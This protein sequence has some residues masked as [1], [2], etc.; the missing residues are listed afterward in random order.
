MKDVELIAI[1]NYQQVREAFAEELSHAF[2]GNMSSISYLQHKL[3]ERPLIQKGIVQGIV[4]GGTN[5]ITTIE[6][7]LSDGKRNTLDLKTG[8]LPNL[9]D[10]GTLLSFLKE[11]VS[12]QALA[13]GINFGFPL[14]PVLGP[15]G[16]LD[17]K[18]IEPTKEH[19]FD[20]LIGSTIG[21]LVREAFERDIPVSVANDTVCLTLAGND[22]EDGSMIAGT[23]FNIGL[24][25][26]GNI[27]VN[28]EAGNF[29]KFEPSEAIVA[30]DTFS[31][32]PGKQLFEKII[33]GKYLAEVFNIKAEKMGLII[34]KLTT[35][36]EL[37]ALSQEE[38][39]GDANNIARKLLERSAF[40]VAA[41]LA[42]VYDFTDR[43]QSLTIIGEGSL[44]WRG[45]RYT[46]NIEKQLGKLGVPKN[47]I[48]IKHVQDSSIRGAIGLLTS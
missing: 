14:E 24:R 40:L 26:A 30:V 36:Q 38:D 8:I 33:S 44:L 25:Q 17:G 42:G 15:H 5:Y 6:D 23:G 48:R 46:E 21:D 11:H 39:D 32:M 43:P 4:I 29:D 3:P 1:P 10:K 13:V 27:V 19:A 7:V 37:S 16:E 28:L 9:K 22:D 2:K 31:D 45:W 12:N 35:S 47:A 41:A 34:P 20:G 18:L